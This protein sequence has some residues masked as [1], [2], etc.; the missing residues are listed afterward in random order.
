[1]KAFFLTMAVMFALVPSMARAE[2]NEKMSHEMQSRCNNAVDVNE[3]AKVAVYCQEAANQSGLCA[4]AEEQS[5][6]LY[7]GDLGSKAALM[8]FSAVG[9]YKMGKPNDARPLFIRARQIATDVIAHA[10]RPDRTNALPA[11]RGA[12]KTADIWLAKYKR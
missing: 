1:M 4:D 5:P 3:W 6:N 2:C 12:I 9:F 7:Y 11:A 10:P 8:V